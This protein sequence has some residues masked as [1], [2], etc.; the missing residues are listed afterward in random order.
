MLQVKKATTLIYKK[1]TRNKSLIPESSQ[2]K[3]LQDCDLPIIE[4]T[5]HFFTRVREH[6]L[7]DN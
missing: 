5:Q 2:K 1:L 4:T 3:W 7:S 6:L